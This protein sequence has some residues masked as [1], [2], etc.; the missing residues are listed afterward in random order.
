MIEA[1]ARTTPYKGLV[2]YSDSDDDAR[3]FFGR[4]RERDAI[5]ANLL[6]ARLTVL[7]GESGVGKTSVLHAGVAYHLRG[8]AQRDLTERG[9]PEAIV[10]VF[11]RWRDDPVGGLIAAVEG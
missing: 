11:D 3:L 6:T 4:E 2:P 9:A 5:L 10:T 8:R 1:P 7:Y